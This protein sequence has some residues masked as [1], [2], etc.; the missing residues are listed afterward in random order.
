MLQHSND[1]DLCHLC[2]GDIDTLRSEILR[3]KSELACGDVNLV[4]TMRELDIAEHRLARV[5]PRPA[6]R[7]K[8]I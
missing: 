7:L 5:L 8:V 4:E 6:V 2:A 1:N 3:L